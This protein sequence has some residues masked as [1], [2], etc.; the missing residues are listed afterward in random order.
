M[1]KYATN[2]EWRQYFDQSNEIIEERI[3]IVD[4]AKIEDGGGYIFMI[5]L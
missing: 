3:I 1:Q 4:E 2:L 5:F